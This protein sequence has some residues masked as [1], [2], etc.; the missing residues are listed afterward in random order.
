MT[1]KEKIIDCAL[2]LFATKGY[3]DVYVGE[4]ADAVGIKAPSL[5]KHFKN[6]Q[7][8]FDALIT[9]MSERYSMQAAVFGLDGNDAGTDIA[10]YENISEDMLVQM[11]T[12][13]FAYFLHDEYMSRFRK[14]LTLEQFNNPELSKLYTRQFYEDPI[15]YQSQ[16]FAMLIRGKKLRGSDPKLMALEFYSP[17]YMLLTVCDRDPSYE[18]EAMKILEKH[19]RDFNQ[20]HTSG[21]G[22]A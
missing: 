18:K 16:M 5:Y 9:T 14:V 17:I 7:E 21:K 8:I 3:G 19:I 6:K 10:I 22:K 13:L 15:E 1:T 4:I 2:T 20:R 12:G 11:G